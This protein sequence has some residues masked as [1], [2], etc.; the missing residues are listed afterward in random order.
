MAYSHA[1]ALAWL[2]VAG[3]AFAGDPPK[4]I[5]DTLAIQDAMRQGRELLTRGEAAKAVELLERHLTKVSGDPAYLTLLKDAY[6]AHLKD[7]Q[8]ANKTE[9]C[10]LFRKRLALIDQGINSPALP[11][12]EVVRGARPDEDPFGQVPLSDKAE[13]SE[14]L[15]MAGEA[16]VGKKYTEAEELFARSQAAGASLSADHKKQWAYCKLS[17]VVAKVNDARPHPRAELDRCVRDALTLAD[18]DAKLVAFGAELTKEIASRGGPE[19]WTK[20]EGANFRVFHR[21]QAELAEQV[22]KLAEQHRTAAFTKWATVPKTSWQPVCEVYLYPSADDYA[23]STGQ[24]PTAPGHSTIKAKGGQVLARRM[25]LRADEPNLLGSVLPHETTH[26][27]LGDLFADVSLP[28]WADEGMAV[29][30]EPRAQIERYGK[31]LMSCRQRGQLLPLATILGKS[32][33]YPEA[34][35]ITVFYVESVSVVEFLVN[36]RGPAAFVAFAREAGGGLDAALTKHYS[37]RNVAE[38]QDKWLRAIIT[39][40]K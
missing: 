14:L 13:S 32:E 4:V 39:P 24:A 3:V 26:V 10:E 38:L 29:L 22:A 6:R 40:S 33:E 15:A 34:A 1:L 2:L 30:A 23:K 25:D 9:T 28:R 5:N 8:L 35:T 17:G 21:G 36:Q 18:G 31:T 12:P 27:V 16:F 20:V 37:I 19:G 11:K 7:L